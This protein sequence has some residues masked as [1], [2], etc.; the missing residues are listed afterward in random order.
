MTVITHWKE[1]LLFEAVQ[2]NAGTVTM[3][4]HVQDGISPKALLLAGLAGCSAVD[5]VEI[6]E[7]MRVPF[8]RLTVVSAADQTTDHP[9]VF[10]DI[11]LLY[12]VTTDPANEDKL[13]K[14]IDL[15]LE[16]YCGV[17][18]MLRKNSAIRYRCEC[19][20]PT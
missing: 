4:G 8:T 19:I 9:R 12:T 17:A 20:R 14:A 3:D 10:T 2:E 11:D 7:K 5:V 13:R 15:S 18:A 6:L 1:K 16:K